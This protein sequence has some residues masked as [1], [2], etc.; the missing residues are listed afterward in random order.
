MFELS[1][2]YFGTNKLQKYQ[3]V[4][5]LNLVQLYSLKLHFFMLITKLRVTHQMMF[6]SSI[7]QFRF[8]KILFKMS[9]FYLAR[10]NYKNKI[11][12]TENLFTFTIKGF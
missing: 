12:I 11:L 8:C 2:L 9:L 6:M 5:K 10:L 4:D 1:L 7:S 3:D